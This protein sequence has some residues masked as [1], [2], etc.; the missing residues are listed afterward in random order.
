MSISIDQAEKLFHEGRAIFIDARAQVFYEAGHIRGAINLPRKNFDDYYQ[1]NMAGI[2][3]GKIL[4]TYCDGKTCPLSKDVAADL[5]ELDHQ[6]VR[7]LVD[8][9]KRWKDRYLPLE[10]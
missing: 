9:W 7:V 10:P 1:K 6:N 4:I 2:P 3:T 5:I 8:G